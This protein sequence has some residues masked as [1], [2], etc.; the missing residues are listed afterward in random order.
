MDR[1]KEPICETENVP[2][3]RPKSRMSFFK[4]Q[5]WTDFTY[6]IRV[7]I[8]LASIPIIYTL[9]RIN[10]TWPTESEEEEAFY[11]LEPL[12]LIQNLPHVKF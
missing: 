7:I 8:R 1:K 3:M 5:L 9:V 12:T 2:E 4:V 11:S 6:C 10:K